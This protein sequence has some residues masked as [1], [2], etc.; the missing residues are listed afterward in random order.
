MSDA[1]S[2][3][4][5][6]A[7]ERSVLGACVE[8]A[9]M[10]T[11]ALAEGISADDFSVSDH[12]RVFRALLEMRDKRIPIDC[13]SVSEQLGNDQRD[14]ALLGDLTCG[15]IIHPS[16]VAHH[17]RIVRNKSRLRSLLRL[18]DWMAREAG[19]PCADPDEI[20]KLACEKLEPAS[21]HA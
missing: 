19:A 9:E 6:Q 12:Q 5:N 20:A 17:A 21:V 1:G 8:S 7:A 4:V 18:S 13:I 3:P 14:F 15:A 10:L 2:L 16:H 11:A